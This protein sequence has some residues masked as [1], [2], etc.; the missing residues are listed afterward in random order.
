M[1]RLKR[2]FE[3]KPGPA[4][5][6]KPKPPT[7]GWPVAESLRFRCPLCGM[8]PEAERLDD[9]PF[10]A[11]VKLQRF[12]GRLPGGKGFMEYGPASAR[13][14]EFVIKALK[15]KI[16]EL[17]AQWGLTKRE[18]E[19]PDEGEPPPAGEHPDAAVLAQLVTKW[20]QAKTRNS[21]LALKDL[22]KLTATDTGPAREALEAYREL[23]RSDYDSAED[24]RDARDEAW[25]EFLDEL[26]GLEPGDLVD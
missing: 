17:A 16:E 7:P 14:A 26:E 4:K 12:G 13:E 19:P 1:P 3:K 5:R 11:E 8:L 25:Q 2:S 15:R 6:P 9:S 22:E 24:Y 21:A 20:R 10:P 18:Q 23:D